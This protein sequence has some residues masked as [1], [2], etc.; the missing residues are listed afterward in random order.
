VSPLWV[1]GVGSVA[2]AC[3]VG[4]MAGGGVS[5]GGGGD[6]AGAASAVAFHERANATS[7]RLDARTRAGTMT[8]GTIAPSS[9]VRG[10][11]DYG[12]FFGETRKCDVSRRNDCD[13]R[14]SA[15]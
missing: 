11:L 6:A 5:G 9:S 4:V 12:D 1:D 3:G 8:E 13:T 10:A 7:S 2:G 15:S 14:S